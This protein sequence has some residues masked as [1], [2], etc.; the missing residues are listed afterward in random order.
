M[1]AAAQR[2][3]TVVAHEIPR[4]FNVGHY[5]AFRSVLLGAG[6]C[7]A[8]SEDKYHHV[9]V[10]FFIPSVYAGYQLYKHK[11]AAAEWTRTKLLN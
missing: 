11:D 1:N 5:G 4:Q 6:I 10:A 7:Y 2:L 8:I 9:P 3:K